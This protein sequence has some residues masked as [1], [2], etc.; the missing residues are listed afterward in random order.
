M[1]HAKLLLAESQTGNWSVPL[2]LS[3][4]YVF[5]SPS[6]RP[7]QAA[8]TS[9][10][11]QR[12]LNPSQPVLIWLVLPSQQG[13]TAAEARSERNFPAKFKREK[14]TQRRNKHR[15][16]LSLSRRAAVFAATSSSLPSLRQRIP[17]PRG[18]LLA[19]RASSPAREARLRWRRGAKGWL[20]PL[21]VGPEA[22]GGRGFAGGPVPQSPAGARGSRSDSLGGRRGECSTSSCRRGI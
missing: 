21:A 1:E 13:S 3:P 8:N 7:C 19:S 17:W 14:K 10:T 20:G 9:V 5:L 18:I 11:F 2:K 4:N 15:P 12:C 22:G 6:L 16:N